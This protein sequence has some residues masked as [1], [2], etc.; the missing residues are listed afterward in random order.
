MRL[1]RQKAASNKIQL[2]PS[3][4]DRIRIA[5]IWAEYNSEITLSLKQKCEEALLESG[6]PAGNID[7][8]SVPGC[9]EIPFIAQKLAARG[10][11][12]VL[13]ALGAV[14]RGDTHHFELVANECARGVMEVSLKHGVPIIFEV[15]PRTIDAMPCA[16]P[17]TTGPTKG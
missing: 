5:I 16:A 4:A 1:K 10:R 9:F 15:W 7:H 13:V 8:F 11:Y 12:D 3:V 14:I 2:A 6:I 17:A